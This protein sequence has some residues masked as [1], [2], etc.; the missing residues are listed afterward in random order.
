M[1]F[2][3]QDATRHPSSGFALVASNPMNDMVMQKRLDIHRLKDLLL[4]DQW[5]A[6]VPQGEWSLITFFPYFVHVRPFL[7]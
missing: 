5:T 4:P 3:S 7:Q 6:I 2:H 1:R